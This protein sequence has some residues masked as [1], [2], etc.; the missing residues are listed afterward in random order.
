MKMKKTAMKKKGISKAFAG[1]VAFALMVSVFLPL[2]PANASS[3]D[4]QTQQGPMIFTPPFDYDDDITSTQGEDMN[5][6]GAQADADK[7][8]GKMWVG[9][10]ILEGGHGEDI[11]FAEI[12]EFFSSAINWPEAT[13]TFSGS[14]DGYIVRA[15]QNSDAELIVGRSIYIDNSFYRKE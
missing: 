6:I 5:L 4:M 13:I 12:G 15:Q 7:D 14:L 2:S 1:F 8:T 11:G 10:Q 9:A 3:I